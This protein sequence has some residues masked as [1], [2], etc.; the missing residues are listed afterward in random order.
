[1]GTA[2]RT[3]RVY[4]GRPVR[5]SRLR[6]PEVRPTP[7]RRADGVHTSAQ[8]ARWGGAAPDWS[9]VV[10]RLG[11]ARLGRLSVGIRLRGVRGC[12][13]FLV[14][15]VG[16]RC[17]GF[18]VVIVGRRCVG[19]LVVIVGRR[20]V[21]FLVV[22]VGRRC[23]GFLV[24]RVGRRLGIVLCRLGG[25]LILSLW[26]FVRLSSRGYLDLRRVDFGCVGLGRDG[27]SIDVGFI[28]RR[29]VGV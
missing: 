2:E 22:I 16:R 6:P 7:A 25:G 24:V 20:C 15:I 9:S 13:D 14:D 3:S 5:C 21:G 11:R 1:M 27:L 19:F 10:V 23:V 28:D 12:V 29:R 4:A 17:V 26:G 18:L 8:Q